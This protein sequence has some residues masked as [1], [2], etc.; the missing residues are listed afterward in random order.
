LSPQMLV[1]LIVV[2]LFVAAWYS[3]NSK[4]NKIYCFYRGRDNTIQAR[5]VNL[6]D[7]FV[8]FPPNK[9]FRVL[10]ERMTSFWYKGGVHFF[11]PTKVNSLEYSWQSIYP[12]DPHNYQNTWVTPEVY[13]IHNTENA[14]SSYGKGFAPQSGKKQGMIMQ[15]LPIIAIVLIVILGFW[16]Y[17]NFTTIASSLTDLTN[18]VNTIVK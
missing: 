14:F 2:M 11:F 5:W 16:V 13:K 15:Y 12:V 1:T 18:K 7:S 9:K 17:S 6:T 8:L 4:R 3:T 10:P